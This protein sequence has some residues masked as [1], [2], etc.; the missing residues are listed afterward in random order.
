MGLGQLR[1]ED[2]DSA[3]K[4]LRYLTRLANAELRLEGLPTVSLTVSDHG[5]WDFQVMPGGDKATAKAARGR[6]LE[7][8]KG[9]IRSG[10]GREG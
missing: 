8:L 4:T 10:A 7:L 1:G 3:T 6:Y 2:P 5:G 9:A